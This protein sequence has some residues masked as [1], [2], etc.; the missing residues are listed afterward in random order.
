[1]AHPASPP[2]AV[3]GDAVGLQHFL[4][5]IGRVPLLS[6]REEKEL[7][8]R[9]ER[10]DLAAKRRM[11]ESNLRLV[12]S[13][14]RRYGGQNLP[15]VDLIQEGTIGLIRAVEKFDHRQGFKF[16]TYAVWWIRQA[17]A[18]ALS[19][20]GRTIRL[21][22]HIAERH[23]QIVRSE[24]RLAT[25]LGRDPTIADLAAATGFS[26]DHVTEILSWA[27]SA[28]SLQ[29]PVGEDDGSE[30]GEL[31]PD[32]GAADP[33]L[34]AARALFKD[35]VRGELDTLPQRE[36]QVLEL[37]YGLDD[38]PERTLAEIGRTLGVTRERVRQIEQ[39]TLVK[40]SRGG[41]ASRLRGAAQA[42]EAL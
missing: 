38:A 6:A 35:A 36:R 4:D 28:V 5:S 40:L 14:A 27:R 19:E 39:Q 20:Q 7:A 17:V 41:R 37:R 15:L 42:A 33:E 25:E 22:M 3:N 21:P 26:P 8:R 13:I 23:D 29:T 11:I 18:R 30:L 32:E 9:V 2:A 34:S 24:R 31:I 10:G 12:V 16:S 1:M